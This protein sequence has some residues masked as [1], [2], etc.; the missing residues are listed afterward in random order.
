VSG[1]VLLWSKS[2]L[3]FWGWWIS[4]EL[5]FNFKSA[6]A[7]LENFIIRLFRKFGVL[8]EQGLNYIGSALDCANYF[9]GV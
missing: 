6:F 8:W 9:H 2:K 1:I 5:S 4:N 7:L 3:D